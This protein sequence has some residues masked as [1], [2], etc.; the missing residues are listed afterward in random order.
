MLA[1]ACWY[2]SCTAGVVG[3]GSA[4]CKL[5]CRCHTSASANFTALHLLSLKVVGH[6][7][8]ELCESR[9]GRPGLSVL[10][11]LLVSVDVKIY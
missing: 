2:C 11:S 3:E 7:V 1:T 5:C 9:G 6:I 4:R 10:K 8:Q